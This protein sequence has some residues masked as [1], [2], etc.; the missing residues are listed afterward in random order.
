MRNMGFV[1]LFYNKV[2]LKPKKTFFGCI[3]REKADCALEKTRISLSML[4]IRMQVLETKEKFKNKL[5]L[6]LYLV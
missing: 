4:F 1:I 6:R 3:C 5:R 2:M